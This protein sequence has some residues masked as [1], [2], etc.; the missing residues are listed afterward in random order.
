MLAKDY[1]LTQEYRKTNS[2]RSYSGKPIAEIIVNGFFSVDEKWTVQY[3]NRSAEQLLGIPAKEIVNKNIWEQFG[4]L[5]P[6]RFYSAYHGA[7]LQDIPAHFREYWAE[8]KAWFEVN[9]WYC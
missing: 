2:L 8:K 4:K 6:R 5:L 7:R 3:W 1:L 9:T